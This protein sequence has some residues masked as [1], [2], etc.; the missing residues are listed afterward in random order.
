VARAAEVAS[1]VDEPDGTEVSL[2]RTVGGI[3]PRGVQCRVGC[4]FSET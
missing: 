2:E 1:P 3:V 4:D